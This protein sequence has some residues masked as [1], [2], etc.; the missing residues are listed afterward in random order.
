MTTQLTAPMIRADSVRQKRA[1]FLQRKTARHFHCR[2]KFV[3]RTCGDC[4]SRTQ[5]DMPRKRIA[6][7][8]EIERGVDFFRCDFPGDERTFGEVGCE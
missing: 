6:L 5:D 2:P 8:H 4:V 7:K 3:I 1:M